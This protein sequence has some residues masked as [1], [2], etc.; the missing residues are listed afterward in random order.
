MVGVDRAVEHARRLDPVAPQRRQKRQRG[1][2]FGDSPKAD[3]SLCWS[4]YA[5]VCLDPKSIS[6]RQAI[7]RHEQVHYGV[8]RYLLGRAC[9]YASCCPRTLSR[10]PQLDQLIW[11]RSKLVQ[12]DRAPVG[13]ID[14]ASWPE[15]TGW[16]W[17]P[18]NPT[19]RAILEVVHDGATL[20]CVVADLPRRDLADAGM[21]D[22]HNGF[23]LTLPKQAFG[24]PLVRFSVREVSTGIDLQGSPFLLANDMP[25]IEGIQEQV[26]SFVR[27]WVGGA[28]EQDALSFATFFL[29]QFDTLAG[30]HQTL[31]KARADV[32]A[33]W[34][35]A[36]RNEG[37]FSSIILNHL[38]SFGISM[39]TAAYTFPVR[40]NRR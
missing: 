16:A 39:A 13:N 20:C 10:C 1:L 23:A 22:G 12:E 2:A 36:L 31:T 17:F 14:I 29:K 26:S 35:E 25:D 8:A 4:A 30:K 32:T 7:A 27:R 18:D 34:A 15:L 37:D 24:E 3:P 11:P 38:D 40:R 33:R 28:G 6:S 19:R 5:R 21:G 9:C